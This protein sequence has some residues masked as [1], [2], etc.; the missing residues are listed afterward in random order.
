[1]SSSGGTNGVVGRT[2]L[3]VDESIRIFNNEK[4]S[5]FFIDGSWYLSP[6]RDGRHEYE[7]GPRIPGALFFDIDD[8]ASKGMDLNPKNLPHMMPSK[9][10]FGMVMSAF[11]IQHSDHLIVY[12]SQG[13]RTYTT[14]TLMG[15]DRDKVHLM[16]GSIKE[17]SEKGGPLDSTYKEALKVSDLS[18]DKHMRYK[19]SDVKNV[20]SMNAVRE[21]VDQGN[22]SGTIIID[23][24]PAER[25]EGNAPEPRPGVRR[26]KIPN[27]INVPAN[28]LYDSNTATKFKSTEEMK[29]IF[30][31]AGIDL[32]TDK[33]I[34]CSCGSGVTAC[35]L[36]VAL[37]ELGRD[38]SNT[39]IYDGSWLEWATSSD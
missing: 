32:Q 34:I 1:M 33:R 31:G 25:F 15:H 23:A 6:D 14:L 35:V 21:V 7:K 38:T 27:S 18:F 17:W 8:V 12:G 29:A 24:R 10:L 20:V 13:S 2:F 37:E 28:L 26:G 39:F 9:S 16:Q 3:S 4:I 11:K 19:A 5:S 36:S 30:E 22:D